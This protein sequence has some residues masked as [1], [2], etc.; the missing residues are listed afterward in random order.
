[1]A[2]NLRNR[3][4]LFWVFFQYYLEHIPQT[5]ACVRRNFI[6]CLFDGFV[7]LARILVVERQVAKTHCEQNNAHAPN[8][9]FESVVG[10]SLD[11]FWRRIA[12]TSTGCFEFGVF[13]VNVAQTKIGNFNVIFEIKKQIF[14]F[15]VSVSDSQLVDVLH[16]IDQLLEKLAGFEL[17]EFFLRDDVF[18]EFPPNSVLCDEVDVFFCFYDLVQLNDVGVANLSHDL[19]FA[20]EAVLIGFVGDFTFLYDFEDNLLVGELVFGD[21]DFAEGA[22]SNLF[23]ELEVV[24]DGG[25]DGRI[26]HRYFG[27]HI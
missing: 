2:S 27:T 18:E 3:R 22:H 20:V 8:I 25:L 21:L 1:M 24:D 5:L 6:V 14:G 4:P 26:L 7:E 15:Q 23:A 12:W 13:G 11:H 10:L 19:D 16:S 9:R 17:C